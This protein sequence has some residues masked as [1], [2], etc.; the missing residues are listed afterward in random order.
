MPNL[1]MPQTSNQ[2]SS[3]H[4]KAIDTMTPQSTGE[5]FM[6]GCMYLVGAGGTIYTYVHDEHL[7]A[8]IIA[9]LT[10]ILIVTNIILNIKKIKQFNKTGGTKPGRRR[11][12]E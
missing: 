6:Q 11:P 10:A 1:K 2:G 9:G 5:Y 7:Y 8:G 12:E 3:Q 4:N